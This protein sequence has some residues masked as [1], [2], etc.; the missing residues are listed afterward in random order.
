M[1][2]GHHRRV[3]MFP[4]GSV[5]LPSAVMPL[6]VF[7][8]RYREMI[9]VCLAGER[10]FGVTLIERGSE[11]GGGDARMGFGCVA[12][13]VEA[14]EFDD[15][16]AFVAAV[17]TRRFTVIEWGHDDPYPMADIEVLEELPAQDSDSI[18]VDASRNKLDEVNDLRSRLGA[19]RQP[20]QRLLSSDPALASFQI[21]ALAPL[22]PIDQYRVLSV[23]SPRARLELVMELL[24]EQ[25]GDLEAQIA[26]G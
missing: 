11:V 24:D 22:G 3:P 4:L 6:H 16:R 8:P 7:E 13:I 20:A 9:K 5:L 1:E 25:I 19:P 15:G 23:D 18:L 12:Q 17:G 10:E 2:P 21:A 26:L 14:E